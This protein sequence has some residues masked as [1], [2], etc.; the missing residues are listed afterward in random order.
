MSHLHE[1]KSTKLPK[2]H[3]LFLTGISMPKVFEGA[4]DEGSR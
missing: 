3:L 1:K 4:G 2:R